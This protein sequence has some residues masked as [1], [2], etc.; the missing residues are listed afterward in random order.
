MSGLSSDLTSYVLTVECRAMYYGLVCLFIDSSLF[1]WINNK[2]IYWRT[3][4]YAEKHK[5]E[6]KIQREKKEKKENERKRY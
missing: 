2:D 4:L 3:L 5:A 1:F 6:R